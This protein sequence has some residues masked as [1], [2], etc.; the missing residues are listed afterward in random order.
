MEEVWQWLKLVGICLMLLMMVLKMV[1][2]LWWRPRKIEEHFSRQGIRGPPYHFFVGNVKELVGMM[3]K[4][5]SQP[6][7]FSH[8]ILPRV[9]SFYHN[10]KKI[11]GTIMFYTLYLSSFKCF[12]C[13]KLCVLLELF[14]R[15][16]K[17]LFF[18][19]Q[20]LLFKILQLFLSLDAWCSSWDFLDGS[21]S[22]FL[23][24]P[25]FLEKREKKK[26]YFDNPIFVFVSQQHN[27]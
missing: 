10:W 18:W 5:S 17:G 23:F 15:G 2:L 24:F 19:V 16:K 12:E 13:V 6:M 3:L 14:W 4:A 7:R 9:L 1:V 20:V 25:S 27:K 21:T 8:N 26:L 11:Y 22:V